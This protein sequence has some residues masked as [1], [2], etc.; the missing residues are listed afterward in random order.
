MYFIIDIYNAALSL[1]ILYILL[2]SF[3]NVSNY[4]SMYL[5]FYCIHVDNLPIRCSEIAIS[6]WTRL[7]NH[8]RGMVELI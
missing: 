2:I 7:S 1:F 4:P 6:C 3:I 8:V 5:M